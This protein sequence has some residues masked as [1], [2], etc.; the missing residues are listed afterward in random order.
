M[1]PGA[2]KQ[3]S[4]KVKSRLTFSNHPEDS[5][6]CSASIL[7]RTH[8]SMPTA[9]PMH[10]YSIYV[11]SCVCTL[12]SCYVCCCCI[13]CSQQQEHGLL[14]PTNLLL[15]TTTATDCFVNVIAAA[16]L[17]SILCRVFREKVSLVVSCS[18]LRRRLMEDRTQVM[19]STAVWRNG[20]RFCCFIF[21]S[22][23]KIIL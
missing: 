17:K 21:L 16:Q 7:F 19:A 18:V 20:L 23:K 15:P 8:E 4:K 1:F 13:S 10:P 14:P 11:I 22:G 2:M 5:C 9:G 6:Y 12:L 3:R